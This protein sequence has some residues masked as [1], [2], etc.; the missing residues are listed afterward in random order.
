MQEENYQHPNQDHIKFI[1]GVIEDMRYWKG[2]GE[3]SNFPA[4]GKKKGL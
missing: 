4:N 2:I 1:R 3:R